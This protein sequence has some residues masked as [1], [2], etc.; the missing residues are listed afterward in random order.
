MLGGA[1][2]T[3]PEAAKAA[4]RD[5]GDPLAPAEITRR[6]LDRRLLGTDGAT[7]VALQ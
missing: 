1:V 4:L 2:V 5:A 3:F 6:A 7:R